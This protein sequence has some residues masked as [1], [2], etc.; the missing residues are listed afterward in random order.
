MDALLITW[1]ALAPGLLFLAALWLFDSHG[2]TRP[3]RLLGVVL[4]GGACALLA[5]VLGSVL[6]HALALDAL[7][8]ARWVAPFLDESLKALV[9]VALLRLHRIG[10][11]VDAAILG[12]AAG[13]G[14]AMAGSA[15]YML[16]APHAP[17]ATWVVRGLGTALMQGALTALFAMLLL[18]VLYTVQHLRGLAMA[19]CLAAAIALH[20]AFDQFWLSPLASALGCLLL[21]PVL[22]YGVLRAG[23]A[24]LARWLGPDASLDPQF[25]ALLSSPGPAGDSPRGRYLQ[26]LRRHFDG[27][28]AQDIQ[29]YLRAY[30]ALALRA[31][32]RQQARDAGGPLSA[33]E[34]LAVHFDALDALAQRIGRTGLLALAPLLPMSRQALWRAAT[35][36]AA[37]RPSV[38]PATP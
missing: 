23:Q 34:S 18:E 4:A 29:A 6:R 24:R 13:L 31:R 25:L 33:G 5:L 19:G 15:G 14:F 3:G 10:F 30:T 27:P 36:G 16:A 21:L 1:V 8:Y 9:V 22:L 7:R 20:T 12:F 32:Q 37:A 35:Q 38:T 28:V 11:L 2:L 26:A 17:L